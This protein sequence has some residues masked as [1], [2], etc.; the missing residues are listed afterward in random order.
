MALRHITPPLGE[1]MYLLVISYDNV[2]VDARVDH[3]DY[4]QVGE[5]PLERVSF[6]QMSVTKVLNDLNCK[7][8][9]MG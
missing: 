7:K 4:S 3:T 8:L 5:Q 9:V 2:L 1:T 6:L